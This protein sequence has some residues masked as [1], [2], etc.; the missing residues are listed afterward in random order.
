MPV[1]EQVEG[2]TRECSNCGQEIDAAERACPACGVLES[3]TTCARHPERTAEG[4]CVICGA[5]VCDECTLEGA[6]HYL[7]PDHHSV[8]VI[9]GWAQVYTTA[10]DVEADLIRENLQ[11]EGI[12]ASV[13][14]QKDHTLTVDL[15]DLSP[16]RVLVPAY[17]YRQASA[18][19]ERHMDDRGEVMFAC[20]SCGEAYEPGAQVCAHCGARLPTSV[21]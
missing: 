16:V 1:E 2:P 19:L 5:A 12:D 10:D 14:S 15:G 21:A 20:A 3:P 11:S 7:C 17:A 13:F 8:P 9:A 6:G 4:E 18:V